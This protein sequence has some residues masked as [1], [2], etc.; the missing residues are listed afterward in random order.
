[1]DIRH[2]KM[3]VEVAD[4]KSLTRASENLYLSQSALS[5]QLKEIEQYFQTQIFIRQKKQMLL[6]KEGELVLS[7]SLKILEE[8]E[9]TSKQIRQLKD[10]GAGEIRIST[11]CYTSY[12]WL[13]GFLKEFNAAFPRVEVKV[14]AAATH[15]SAENLL[16]NQIDVGIFENNVNPKFQYTTLFS[17]EFFVI[18]SPDHK[19]ASRKWVNMNDLHE[20]PYI[21]YKI[22][23]EESTLWKILFPKMKPSKVYQMM[24]TEAIFEM[25]KADMGFAVQPHWIAYRYLQSRELV[26]VKID[27][28]GLKRTWYAAVL[29]NKIH[30]PYLQEFLK[31]ISR[32]MK[33]SDQAT[34]WQKLVK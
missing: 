13:S 4:N 26:A 18:V 11:E 16:N 10:K 17:D 8:I 5:H 33:Q 3:I 20:E 28:K 23:I 1:M 24:L 34:T 6:T 27:R 29:K 7:A 14:I 22:P 12:P 30:P 15:K 32:H 21:M 25:V 2:L 9:N 19:W 31:M